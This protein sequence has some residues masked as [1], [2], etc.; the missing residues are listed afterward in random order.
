MQRVYLTLVAL[1]LVVPGAFAQHSSSLLPPAV[2]SGSGSS[3]SEGAAAVSQSTPPSE[4]SPFGRVGVGFKVGLFGLGF[5]AA[6]P[7]AS[8]FNVRGG[9]N[10]FSYT[11]NLTNSG[12]NYNANLRFRSVEASLDWF[13]F[14]GGFHVSPGALLYDGN[15]VTGGAS[16]PGGQTFTLNSQTYTSSA[17]DPVTGTGSVTFVKAAPKLTVGWGSLVPRGERR[18]SFPFEVGFAYVGD[19]TFALNL[20]GTA[21]YNYQGTPYC[22]NVATDSQI[23]SN[24]VA[25]KQ[26][27]N[28]D[29]TAA[30]FFP[31][32]SQGFAVRF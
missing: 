4:S 13:P 25:E 20:Q 14:R 22:D 5:E 7:V 26:K 3:N 11:D 32:L 6:V 28:H 18:F 17:N 12:I 29:L 16:V 8:H 9:A 31:I 27:I 2:L 1:S 30:R 23:Q 10:F 21:C 24:L 19:P 15:Q